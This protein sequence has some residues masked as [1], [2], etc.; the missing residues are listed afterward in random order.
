[1]TFKN[2]DDYIREHGGKVTQEI[3][4]DFVSTVFVFELIDDKIHIYTEDGFPLAAIDAESE[5]ELRDFFEEEFGTEIRVCTYCGAI[6]QAGYT[7]D[8][9]DFFNCEDC[10]ELDMNERYGKGNWRELEEENRLGGYY[11]FREDEECEWEA[12]PTYY[13]E[14]Y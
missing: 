7:D 11:E 10:F 6:I 5:W 1:M 8:D 2:F 4:V 12:E 14:W 3:S 13:T 9:G